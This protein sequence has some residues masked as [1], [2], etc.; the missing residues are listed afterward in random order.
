M[1]EWRRYCGITTNILGKATTATVKVSQTSFEPG[2]P[3]AVPQIKGWCPPTTSETGAIRDSTSGSLLLL[4]PKLPP[5]LVKGS[6]RQKNTIQ[7][8]RTHNKV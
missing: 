7:S 2:T 6:F 3:Y 1:P 8:E 5:D 4:D